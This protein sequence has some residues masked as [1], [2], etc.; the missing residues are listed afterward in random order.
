MIM[1]KHDSCHIETV[2]LLCRKN[3]E[4]EKHLLVEYD[5]EG[6]HMDNASISVSYREIKEWVSEHYNGMKVHSLYI[7]QIKRKYGLIERENYNK[8][9]KP[10]ATVPECP[11]EK[12]AA[13]VNA[14]RHFRLID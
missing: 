12:E 7:A 6:R 2:V 4:A 1:H 5:T 11:P 9:K 13:I 3:E 10:G 8:S 14:L